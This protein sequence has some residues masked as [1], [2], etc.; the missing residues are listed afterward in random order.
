MQALRATRASVTRV[1]FLCGKARMRSPTAVD[2]VGDW[3]GIEADFAGLS[4]DADEPVT[5]DHID[6]AKVVTVMGARLTP[7]LRRI[8]QR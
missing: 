3:P 8:L 6:G 7:L 1:L 4:R 5:G 2:I